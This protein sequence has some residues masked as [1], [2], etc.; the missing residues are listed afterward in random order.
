MLST[1]RRL[2]CV[3]SMNSKLL[4]TKPQRPNYRQNRIATDYQLAEFN[5]APFIKSHPHHLV[6]ERYQKKKPR[7]QD[8]GTHPHKASFLRRLCT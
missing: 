1:G 2:I 4:T 8:R 5:G 6:L 7:Q 3:N